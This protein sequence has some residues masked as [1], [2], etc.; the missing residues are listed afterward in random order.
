MQNNNWIILTAGLGSNDFQ[1]AALRVANDLIQFNLNFDIRVLNEKNL[2]NLCPSFYTRAAASDISKSR[3]YGY[4]FWKAELVCRVF[5]EIGN[6]DLGI[7]WVD[8]GNEVFPSRW[9]KRKLIHMMNVARREGV[10]AYA[11]RTEERKYTKQ[12]VFEHFNCKSAE[13]EDLQFQANFFMLHGATGR[14]IASEWFE[15]VSTNPEL[16]EDKSRFSPEGFVEHRHDQSLFSLICKMNG[17]QPSISPPPTGKYGCKSI[18]KAAFSPI[19]I[20]R[21]RSGVTIKPKWLMKLGRFS[22][23]LTRH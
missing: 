5:E 6:S 1:G 10:L 9:T 11:L 3:G 2:Q 14:K 17:V 20:S 22:M 13:N 12:E 7:I 16:L 15:S 21:N 19:W 18:L 4:W 23:F 8:S